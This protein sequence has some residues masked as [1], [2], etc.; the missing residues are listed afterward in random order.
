MAQ[1]LGIIAGG[2]PL[3]GRLIAACL[4]SG[5]PVFVVAFTGQTDAALTEGAAFDHLWTRLGA[6]GRYLGRLH[7]EGIEELCLIGKFRRPGLREV[8]PDLKAAAFLARIRL[9]ALGDDELL[10]ALRA[11]LEQEGFRVVGIQDVIAGLLARPGLLSQAAPDPLAWSDIRRA[12][13]VARAIGSLDIG[14]A[15]VVQQGVVLAVEAAEGTD[16]MLGRCAGLRRDGPGGVLVKARKPQQDD[17]LDLPTIGVTTVEQ[18]AAAGLRGIAVE[19]GAALVV[20]DAA[21]A[22]AAD[23]LGLFVIAL[24]PESGLSGGA[25]PEAEMPFEL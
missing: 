12:L 15:A 8:M 2:G 25:E 3:P 24:D 20:D 1:K 19:A 9:H 10:Q 18:A 13:G 16:A 23:R 14:Q 7:A 11:A 4:A 22:A 6:A 5:R 21:V 17:R